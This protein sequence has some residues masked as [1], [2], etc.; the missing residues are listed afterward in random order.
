MNQNVLVDYP[1]LRGFR[2]ASR[3][4]VWLRETDREGQ[5]RCHRFNVPTHELPEFIRTIRELR[6][7]VCLSICRAGGSEIDR[8]MGR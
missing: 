7:P 5:E 1:I 2:D 8:E 3:L 4:E 6:G